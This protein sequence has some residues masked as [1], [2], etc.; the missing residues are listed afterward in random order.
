MWRSWPGLRGLLDTM[1]LRWIAP[2][3][4]GLLLF[5]LVMLLL[6]VLSAQKTCSSWCCWCCS[7]RSWWWWW[8]SSLPW[9]ATPG[10]CCCSC[11]FS[12]S[13]CCCSRRSASSNCC[14]NKVESLFRFLFLKRRFSIYCLNVS[15]MF[16]LT[17]RA[18][19]EAP[20]WYLPPAFF[21]N[22]WRSDVFGR[23][24]RE[25]ERERPFSQGNK[26]IQ[27]PCVCVCVCVCL[28]C[29]CLLC[30]REDQE[31]EGYTVWTNKVFHLVVV[32][33]F[34]THNYI[35]CIISFLQSH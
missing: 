19:R 4:P 1:A 32:F 21:F 25:R 12:C 26:Q 34:F 11:C 23:R 15:I 35:I 10:G 30:V 13:S 2:M 27:K 5:A 7:G 29:G 28:L 22:L 24:E 17:T 16:R 8:C 18:L 33:F 31:G 14:W 3:M 9:V 6:N 20:L